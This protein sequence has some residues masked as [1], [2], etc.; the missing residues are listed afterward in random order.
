VARASCNTSRLIQD[1]SA[2]WYFCCRLPLLIKKI[3]VDSMRSRLTAFVVAQI[4]VCTGSAGS[5]ADIARNPGLKL[6]V[7]GKPACTL[8]VVG[9]D[10]SLGL[11]NRAAAAV[12]D[13]VRLWTGVFLN[14]R[15]VSV[16]DAKL[17]VE[18]AIIFATLDA[19]KAIAPELVRT[20][21]ELARVPALDEHGFV[22]VPVE[23]HGAKQLLVV[24]QTPRGV[25]NGAVYLRDFGID[26]P[27]DNLFAEFQS[28]VRSPQMGGRPAYTL[29]IWGH[30]AQYTPKDWATI[31][32]SYAR[33]GIDRVYFWVSGHFPSQKFPQT[34]Y[35]Q[36]IQHGKL[37]DTTKNSRIGTVA[38]LKKIIASAHEQGLRIYLGGGLGCWC[39]T[40]F[41]TNKEAETM[42]SGTKD[43]SLCPSNPKSRQALIDY[44]Q[45]LYA[46]LPESDGLFIESA[47]EAGECICPMCSRPVDELGSRQF[48]Q[49]QLSLCQEIMSGIWRDHPNARFAYTI[50]Y[51][52]HAK[53]VAYYNLIQRLSADPRFEWMEARNSWSFPGPSGEARPA[54]SFSKQVMRWKQHYNVPL[55]DLITDA[56]RAG[57]E[58][59]YGLIWSFEPGFATGSFYKDIIPFPTDLL[60]YALTAFVYREATWNPELSVV[61]M[62]DRVLQR[63]FG[64][65]APAALSDDLWKLREIIR[66][67]KNVKEL[68]AIEQRIQA[69]RTNAGPKTMEGLE[70]MQRA[71]DDI[72]KHREKKNR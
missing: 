63:F 60:P 71:I 46:A 59:L 13:T 18:S 66:T 36:D 8:L 20:H 44:Y 45:E 54:A 47:D 31:F 33:D 32:Q 27:R 57:K 7:S 37:Y 3:E 25:Y 51:Q 70:L 30:E 6:V 1:T 34:Y 41:I 56:N 16:A 5:A 58:G 68:G 42:K 61:E 9:K 39:G 4:F 53:D 24:S 15:T 19:L 23:D 10:E 50:G 11:L 72:R 48:G 12:G 2:I 28:V 67:G 14:S 55:E 17:P 65:E 52:E 22:C 38:D 35:C 40:Q 21:D 29:T 62:R 43:E 26:G 69:A 64:R 49:A